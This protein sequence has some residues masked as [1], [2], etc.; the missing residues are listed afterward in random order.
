MNPAT[1]S[2]TGM[3]IQVLRR[4]DLLNEA[5]LHN[6]NTVAHRHSFGLVVGNIDEGGAQ[7]QVQLRD[8]GSHLCTQ[9]CVQV[10]ERLVKQEDLRVTDDC[11]AQRNTLSLTTGESLRLSVEKV[12]DVEDSSS[13]FYAALDL[14]PSAFCAV[15]G[16]MPC[17]HKRSCADTVHSSG[18]PSRYRD[19]SERR[20]S[21]RTSPM[22]SSPSEISSRPA[23]IRSVVDFTAAGRSNQDDE[24]FV[25]NV[26]AKIGNRSY[27]ALDTPYRC[28]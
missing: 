7:S 24:L 8:L 6:N 12:R 9:L 25:R 3:I 1:N 17:Y 28:F 10:G 21:T 20:R 15:S 19:P 18:T 4:V 11:T 5:V 14:S 22:Y 13:L 27:A 23:I 26:K 2:L 16:R